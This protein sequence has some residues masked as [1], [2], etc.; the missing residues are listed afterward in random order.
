MGKIKNSNSVKTKIATS[1]VLNDASSYLELKKEKHINIKIIL[2]SLNYEMKSR[3]IPPEN[4]T[5]FSL[6]Q[7]NFSKKII[8][9][10]E[11][12]E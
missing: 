10:A 4:S 1:A 9:D 2:I 8:E 12:N 3:F 6:V 5:V 7:I 11:M